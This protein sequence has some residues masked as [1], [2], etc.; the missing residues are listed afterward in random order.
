[1]TLLPATKYFQEFAGLKAESAELF[2]TTA[3]MYMLG[4]I[5]IAVI[6]F[7]VCAKLRAAWLRWLLLCSAMAV[8]IYLSATFIVDKLL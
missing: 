4:T 8:D 5:T 6:F 3:K 7:L 2:I 1:V